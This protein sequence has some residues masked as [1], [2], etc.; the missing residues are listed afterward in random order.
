MV[1]QILFGFPFLISHPVAYVSRAF[2]LGRVFIHFWYLLLSFVVGIIVIDLYTD[3][4]HSLQIFFFWVLGLGG[5]GVV[6]LIEK[7][8]GLDF[9]VVL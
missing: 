1:L 3:D 8:L 6:G 9:V 4:C 5:G 7:H 2:N